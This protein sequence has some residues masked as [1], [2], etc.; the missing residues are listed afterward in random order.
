MR[1]GSLAE[2]AIKILEIRRGVF[3]LMTKLYQ[4]P[5]MS[6]QA[7]IQL[8]YPDVRLKTAELLDVFIYSTV[9]DFTG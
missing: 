2:S 7:K 5:G 4:E 3:I 1:Y 8:F 9:L 6:T